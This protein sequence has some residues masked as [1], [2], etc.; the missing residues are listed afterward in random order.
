MLKKLCRRAGCFLLLLTLLLCGDCETASAANGL[1][2]GDK[3]A[4]T[5][6][7]TGNLTFT[8]YAQKKK[9]NNPYWK[10]VG[11]YVTAEKTSGNGSSRAKKSQCYF[12]A[13]NGGIDKDV[14]G[15]RVKT[16]FTIPAKKFAAI[17]DEAG[18]SYETL[19]KTGGRVY[20]QGVLQAFNA[21]GTPI[22]GY[23]YTYSSMVS[24]LGWSNCYAG[25]RQRYDI[26]V[27]YANILVPVV[28]NY[29]QYYKGVYTCVYSISCKRSP[30][31]WLSKKD[32]G[33]LEEGSG[34]GLDT[35]EY[36]Y[37][38]TKIDTQSQCIPHN[39]SQVAAST[40][41]TD[42]K[43]TKRW[44]LCRTSVSR[45]ADGIPVNGG[46]PKQYQ[47]QKYEGAVYDLRGNLTSAY[48]SWLKD[49]R[50]DF[51][52]DDMNGVT[53]NCVYKKGRI[54]DEDTDD[55][56]PTDDEGKH[57]APSSTKAVIQSD[58]RDAEK[59]DST[60]G[61][62]TSECQYVNVFTD[63]YLYQYH[64]TQT[65]GSNVFDQWIPCSHY[66]PG[67]KESPGYY[68]H[69]HDTTPVTRNY[70]YWVVDKLAV[71]GIAGVQVTNYSL[72]GLT[73]DLCP[74]GGYRRP[75]VD[76]DD[77]GCIVSSPVSGWTVEEYQ[78]RND[79]VVF[80][81]TLIMDNA[82]CETRTGDPQ[83]IPYPPQTG[84][85]VLYKNSL[86]IEWHKTNGEWSSD[87][88]IYYEP[89]ICVGLPGSFI[90]ADIQDINDVIIH[91]PV[92]CYP[93][94]SDVREY[95]Q[96]VSPQ[97]QLV[98]LV[99]DRSFYVTLATYGYH[100]DM[101]GYGERDFGKYIAKRE[102]R[103]PFDVYQGAGYYPA[104]TWIELLSDTTCFYLPI[105]VNETKLA[106]AEF[107]ARTINCD[108]NDA[109]EAVEEY[110]NLDHDN[111]VAVKS[112]DT[113]ISGRLYGL[114]VYDISD[115]P[116]WQDVFRKEG[117]LEL[118]GF[119][120]TVGLNTQNGVRQRTGVT[121]KRSICGITGR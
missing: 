86:E 38:Q 63:E 80:N 71:Y 87:G 95:T 54:D 33:T 25:W 98:H 102:V 59:F 27:K 13:A 68:M 73:V 61:I 100:S 39:L 116:V 26:E 69:D 23:K 90:E 6:E 52:V 18:V 115:Y 65:A 47:K 104:G 67:T 22:T 53:V 110:N 70:S 81:D 50:R 92:V 15:G 57:M 109:L 114:N 82:V 77:C 64:Y 17:C 21:N 20:L 46:F 10:T 62:P 3:A 7:R 48:K 31:Q 14:G 36:L 40:D 1:P 8:L 42:K 34:M 85:D 83:D 58:E 74:S 56:V 19:K 112:I 76:Y 16:V 108:P 75:V 79:L 60:V 11:F 97:E 78:V 111:Y 55:P 93:S 4:E 101:K 2:A 94:I 24:A 117:S 103:F 12:F 120:Y 44:V 37:K 43:Q 29:Y 32:K 5:D 41:I 105:W 66:V 72:P 28:F 91:T 49:A 118:R 121:G 88:M 119:T 89:V 106:T 51:V 96:L 84:R 113:E 99:L 107:R 9:P 30:G 35:T 45:A